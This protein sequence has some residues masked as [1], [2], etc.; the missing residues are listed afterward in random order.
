MLG[1]VVL[2]GWVPLK[3]EEFGSFDLKFAVA[4]QTVLMIV[5][6]SG[7]LWWSAGSINQVDEQRELAKK[8]EHDLRILSDLDP[9]TGLLNRR[10]FHKRLEDAWA[11]S[12]RH[13]QPLGFIML[14]IDYFK[15]VNDTYGHSAGDAVIRTV[16]E[17]LVAQC[18]PTDVVCR[19]GGEEFC[20]LAA[21]TG[22][23]GAAKLAERIRHALAETQLEV[24]DT[25][26]SLSSSFGVTNRL[27]DSDNV[28]DL[29]ERADQA[30]HAAKHWGR[31]RVVSFAAG[32][33][34]A[35]FSDEDCTNHLSPSRA[36]IARVTPCVDSR[37][38]GEH[39]MGALVPSNS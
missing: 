10:S 35:E 28:D 8:A 3:A 13:G 26:L 11:R 15:R 19:Y 14:D 12:L 30:L 20:I 24:R 31:N 22:I 18:R 16:A 5:V 23:A 27:D 33:T 29:I 37:Q 2:L 34:L 7:L 9:L 32:D 36:P 21:Q 25:F 6:F 39:E 1:V 4:I 38:A 17:L